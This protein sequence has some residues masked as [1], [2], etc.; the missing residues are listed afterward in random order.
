MPTGSSQLIENLRDALL[1]LVSDN[2]PDFHFHLAIVTGGE[3][4]IHDPPSNP[5]SE[6]S[7]VV[8]LPTSWGP[9]VL[10]LQPHPGPPRAAAA[11]AI[12]FRCPWC[13]NTVK[14]SR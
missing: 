14:V 8:H 7:V 3:T 13:S 10:P 1:R 9:Y 12:S 5:R 2:S 11:P 6:D 4:I